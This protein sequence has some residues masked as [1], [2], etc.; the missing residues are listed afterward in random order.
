MPEMIATKR[1]TY[2][3]R[4]LMADEPFTARTTGDARLLVALGNARYVTAD[5]KAGG[6]Q[7][8]APKTRAAPENAPKPAKPK[9]A[10]VSRK[11][12]QA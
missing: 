4:R 1:L 3:T 2:G 9:A 8:V 11:P 12:K 6:A 10:R 5:A 7:P